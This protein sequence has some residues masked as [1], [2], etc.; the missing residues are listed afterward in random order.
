[1]S[2]LRRPSADIIPFVPVLAGTSR[3]PVEQRWGWIELFAGI[4]LLWGAARLIASA[5][6]YRMLSRA[7]PFVAS[8]GGLVFSMRR[9]SRESLP[10]SGRWLLASFALLAASLLHPDT[11]LKAGIAQLV[12]QISIAAP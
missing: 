11:N 7:A 1:M 5:Q 10:A 3:A 8:L 6:S 9:A 2:H 12:F 4:Q